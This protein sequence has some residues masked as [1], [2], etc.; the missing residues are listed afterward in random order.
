MNELELQLIKKQNGQIEKHLEKLS[1]EKDD[2]DL[3]CVDIID[4]LRTL[5][6]HIVIYHY[7]IVNTVECVLTKENLRTTVA[8]M[9]RQGQSLA[10]LTELHY[11]LQASASHYVIDEISAPRLLWKYVPNLLKMRSWIKSVH[12][13]DILTN[14]ENVNSIHS[15]YL[16]QYY[17]EIY[18]AVLT[19]PVNKSEP[20]NRYYVYKSV[21]IV[22]NNSVIYET[23]VGLAS[24]YST[25]FNQFIVFSSFKIDQRYAIRLNYVEKTIHVNSLNIPIKVVSDYIISIRPCEFNNLGKL[26]GVNADVKSLLHEYKRLMEYMTTNHIGLHEIVLQEKKQYNSIKKYILQNTE[27]IYIFNVLDKVKAAIDSNKHG[28]NVLKYLMVTMNNKLIKDQYSSEPN[29][30]LLNIKKQ[31][32]DSLPIAMSL[33]GHNTSILHLMEVFD[34]DEKDDEL[35]Y[36]KIANRT[37]Q[38]GILYHS[39][40]DLKIDKNE[41]IRL[42][43]KINQKLNWRPEIKIVNSG[44][45]FYIKQFET[46][47]ENIFAKLNALES[48]SFANYNAYIQNEINRLSYSID[49]EEKRRL[50]VSLLSNSSV[51]CIF[52]PAGTGK[53]TM[54]RH[55][56]ILFQNST[57]KYLS[58]THPAVMN[59]YR[60]IGGNWKDYM[61]IKKYLKRPS[62]CDFLFIDECSMVS[63]KDLNDILNLGMFKYLILLGDIYQIQ[64]IDFGSWFKFSNHLLNN[65][66]V[67]ELTELHRTN[68]QELTILW[69][70]VRKKENVIDE[71]LSSFGYTKE[72][73]DLSL[74][75][76]RDDQII[77]CLSYDGLY[78]INN[79]NLIMQGKNETT[80]FE[81]G[82]MIYKVGDPILFLDNNKYAAVLYNNLKGQIVSIKEDDKTLTF[83]LNVDSNINELDVQQFNGGVTIISNN[84]DGTTNISLSVEKE[85]DS[86]TDETTS[87]LVPFQIAYAVSIHKAQ[88]LE[89]KNVKI[90]IDEGCDEM[91]SHD[92]FYTAITRATESLSIYW[93]PSTQQRV[94]KNIAKDDSLK[95]VSIFASKHSMRVKR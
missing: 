32:F 84:P 41:A 3:I 92:I 6:E 13:I 52:G 16:S 69:D 95:D 8:F 51:A 2:V 93:T 85:F 19:V 4:K 50:I 5:V 91:V 37:N 54:A 36:R 70:Y 60:K 77:L 63:N 30:H 1:D 26:V 45:L 23:T 83:T 76:K 22:T 33:V 20:K 7:G 42:M 61:T 49:S 31:P 34:L 74:F 15:E 78:G 35:F 48:R 55:I 25:K 81:I 67:N 43:T 66:A 58:N 72:L 94:L 64:A 59:M 87:K 17:D 53:S 40:S 44:D 21:P 68:K 88:G 39:C 56:S 46:I 75:D 80:K 57:K 29:Y 18:N 28:S 73:D 90:V 14:L 27:K 89:Y 71:I 62:S 38:E 9:K 79:L 11:Y 82:N 65:K 24:D 10:F 47:T 86:D 12:D